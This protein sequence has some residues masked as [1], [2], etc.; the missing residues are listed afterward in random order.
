MSG[1]GS[2]VQH[3]VVPGAGT[4]AASSTATRGASTE[5][6]RAEIVTA[7]ALDPDEGSGVEALRPGNA[8]P[9]CSTRRAGG[10]RVALRLRRAHHALR[11]YR[12]RRRSER[13]MAFT[14][15]YSGGFAPLAAS[16]AT[17]SADVSPL[18]MT[19]VPQIQELAV[20][21]GSSQGLLF[22]SLDSI[23]VHT[24]FD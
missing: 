23:A 19:F 22:V 11:I 6:S 10:A 13:D 14:W 12:G 15:Q 16:L 17:T 18:S 7:D 8:S 4:S 21:D 5:L 1:A 3:H 2:G 9:A 20:T 24:S